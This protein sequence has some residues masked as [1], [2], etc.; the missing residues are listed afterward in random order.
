MF[1]TRC[2]L[3][4]HIENSNPLSEIN[5]ITSMPT[6]NVHTITK[7]T[8]SIWRMNNCTTSSHCAIMLCFSEQWGSSSVE[9]AVEKKKFYPRWRPR[10][11][12]ILS[13]DTFI[14]AR[15]N[16]YISRLCYDVS[17]RLFVTEVHVC[18]IANLGFKF[19]SQSVSY[20]HLTLPTILRV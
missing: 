15:C 11:C 3:L 13:C 18:I 20:T 7:I 16:I 19:W 8:T 2:A 5:P 1:G 6:L 9:M 17:V 14:S 4:F 10:R 12:W